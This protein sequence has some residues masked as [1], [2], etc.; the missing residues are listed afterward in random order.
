[1][2]GYNS[3]VRINF[4]LDSTFKSESDGVV[5]QTHVAKNLNKVRFYTSD[6]VFVPIS[7]SYD[8]TDKNFYERN[9][10]QRHS[11][12]LRSSSDHTLIA[13]I[14][15]SKH[16]IKVYKKISLGWSVVDIVFGVF[17]WIVDLYTGNLNY[18]DPI[19]TI[20]QQDQIE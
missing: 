18:F 6:S 11:I 2:K 15:E 5:T 12:F 9:A 7:V 10:Y 20:D 13:K 19:E 3:E 8:T 16:P 17:P 14:G 4:A 1:M